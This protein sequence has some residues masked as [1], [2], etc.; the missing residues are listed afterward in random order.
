MI[1][2]LFTGV[3][4]I[5]KMLNQ[6]EK[7]GTTNI[8]VKDLI[9]KMKV[10]RDHTT[11][12]CHPRQPPTPGGPRSRRWPW[13]RSIRRISTPPWPMESGPSQIKITF[14]TGLTF[15]EGRAYQ[16]VRNLSALGLVAACQPAVNDMPDT[17]PAFAALV[18]TDQ[19]DEA[20][21]QGGQGG[22]RH[23]RCC[24]PSTAPRG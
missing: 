21:V 20:L 1:Q 24:P 13:P 23:R 10:A 4:K 5:E 9:E 7:D 18:V 19:D 11:R 12:R 2:L 15:K 6:L 16:V 17:T 8:D 22:H 14:T 3:D